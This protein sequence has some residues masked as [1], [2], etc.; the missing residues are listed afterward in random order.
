MFNLIL[1]VMVV[2]ILATVYYSRQIIYPKVYSHEDILSY[3]L[4]KA[5][6]QENSFEGYETEHIEFKSRFGY[7]LKG[8]IYL[9][10]DSDKFVILC[11]GITSNYTGMKKYAIMFLKMGYSVLLYDHRNHGK[12]DRN[13]TSMGYYEK[14]DAQTCY[15]YLEKKYKPRHIGVMGESMGASTAMQFA[16]IEPGLAF[17]IEDCGYS[18]AYRLFNYRASHDHHPLIA[19]LTRPTSFYI[20]LFYRWN[21]KDISFD[22]YQSK[23][24]CP[25]MFIHGEADNYVPTDMVHE[26]YEAFHGQKALLTIP[27]AKHAYSIV[28]DRPTYEAAVKAFIETI[29]V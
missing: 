6:I 23:I 19:L 1:V 24:Q 14:Y 5:A 26:M 3:E 2:F 10:D 25:T 16:S 15:E 18:D 29:E 11:H 8:K 22:T 20:K 9:C 17:C 28:V 21:F 12:S 4:E 7:Q 27:D 13:Y